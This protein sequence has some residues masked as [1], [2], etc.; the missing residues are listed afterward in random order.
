MGRHTAKVGRRGAAETLDT[1]G[2]ELG[3]LSATIGLAADAL[4][5]PIG[6]QAIDQPGRARTREQEPIGEVAHPQPPI[7]RR[8]QLDEDVV[9]DEG[10]IML[11]HELALELPGKARVRAQ[12]RVPGAEP[13]VVARYL[14]GHTVSVRADSCTRNHLQVSLHTQST[15]TRA[16]HSH[17][18]QGA[19]DSMTWTLDPAHSSV[20]FSAKHMMVTTVRGTMAI[21]D[22][23]LDFDPDALE[24]SSV[25]VSLDAASINTGQE[26]RDQHLRSADFLQTE[27]YPTIEFA[28]TRIEPAGSGYRL[29]GNLT[30]RGET[31]P[32]VLDAEFAGVV[33][34][35][36][37]GQRAAF[38]A[39]TKINREDF[40]LTWNVALEQGGWLVSKDITIDIDLAATS[41]EQAAEAQ[42]E[43]EEELERAT[44]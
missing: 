28:S 43:A 6:D 4:D 27:A 23:D 31:R 38:S 19:T 34:N 33:P 37:G 5:V 40:G 1:G 22:F 7:V 3:P 9:V 18:T 12:E 39:R 29:H 14:L 2:G 42:V 25:R 24:R 21:R 11:V 32:V 41:S 13:G 20:G 17:A 26:A 44:A 30:I 35:L 10:Q 36:Q 15:T 16:T 8:G